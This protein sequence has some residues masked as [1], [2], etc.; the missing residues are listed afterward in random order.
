MR[1]PMQR[2]NEAKN[3]YRYNVHTI[4]TNS[5]DVPCTSF[6]AVKHS[7]RV[8]AY[9][10]HC[11]C[12]CIGVHN[13]RA[14]AAHSSF[15]GFPLSGHQTDCPSPHIQLH[16]SCPQTKGSLSIVSSSCRWFWILETV[17]PLFHNDTS[18]PLVAKLIRPILLSVYVLPLLC[19]T[20][21]Y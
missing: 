6:K 19:N 2:V 13:N 10:V 4:V 16:N 8:L 21:V 1:K 11:I 20:N 3:T 14:S 15:L 9:I 17:S 12:G 18:R 7:W 5:L